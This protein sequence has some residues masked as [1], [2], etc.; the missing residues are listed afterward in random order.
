MDNAAVDQPEVPESAGGSRQSP[1]EA[2]RAERETSRFRRLRSSPWVIGIVT[3]LLSGAIVAFVPTAS[4]QSTL[5]RVSGFLAK[6]TCDDPRWL[7]Q[8]PDSDIFAAAYYE[9]RD[10]IPD[11]DLYHAP[12][13][14]VDG[15]LRTSWLQLW[16][17]FTTS[18]GSKSSDY[19]EWQF[20]RAYKLRLIC[21]IDGWTEDDITYYRTLPVGTATV[22][23]TNPDSNPPRSGSPAPERGCP[24]RVQRFAD[25]L[26]PHEELS[27]TYQWQPIEFS[28][29]ARDVVLHI[30]TV[31][32]QSIKDRPQLAL[33]ELDGVKRP[34]TG[35]SEIRFYYCPTMLC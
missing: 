21:V 5:A 23:V 17:S 35:I 20:P 9:Q 4:G 32:A 26:A 10:G 12:Q 15:D 30:D 11:Y 22:Y 31:D 25:Y 19:I 1:A 24:V 8:I 14:T 7:V 27:Y 6:P 2:G 28:C 16:P 18:L 34:I 33:S 3:G 13:N 29:R